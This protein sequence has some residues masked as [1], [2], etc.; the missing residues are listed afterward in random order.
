MR[1]AGNRAD[2]ENACRGH[3]DRDHPARALDPEGP[4]SV[5]HAK[6]VVADDEAVTSENLTEAALD[7]NILSSQPKCVVTMEACGEGDEHRMIGHAHPKLAGSPIGVTPD[8][9]IESPV[10][11]A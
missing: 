9:V 10:Q 8:L 6:A 7:R 4:G 11:H 3:H 5:L 2:F 1:P